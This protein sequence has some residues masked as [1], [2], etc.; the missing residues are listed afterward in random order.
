MGKNYLNKTFV[1]K[2]I[3]K[4]VIFT[5]SAAKLSRK[6]FFQVLKEA[7]SNFCINISSVLDSIKQKRLSI[8]KLK[9]FLSSIFTLSLAGWIFILISFGNRTFFLLK[10]TQGPVVTSSLESEHR[11]RS[12]TM[13]KISKLPLEVR[14]RLLA[15]EYYSENTTQFLPIIDK[16]LTEKG[17]QDDELFIKGMFYVGEHESHWNVDR[18]SSQ[19]I[20]GGH[21][22]GIFQFL[23]GTFM[24]VSDGDIYNVEDQVRAFIT[25]WERG[26]CDEF[27]VVFVCGWRPCLDGEVNNYLLKF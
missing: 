18:V 19:N 23:P 3:L 16:V 6:S 11:L 13:S 20:G 10:Q 8:S 15:G 17:L 7:I 24:S 25:M 27:E 22:T 2:Y 1:R 4:H 14:Y 5:L 9:L 21:P 12:F 26:R